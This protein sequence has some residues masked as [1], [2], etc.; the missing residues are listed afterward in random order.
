MLASTQNNAALLAALAGT[1]GSVEQ[2]HSDVALVTPQPLPQDLRPEG[3]QCWANEDEWQWAS[4]ADPVLHIELRKWAR[5]LVVVDVDAQTLAKIALGVCDD[6]LTCVLRAWNPARPV[7]LVPKMAVEAW[8]K[9][10][11]RR[12]LSVIAECMPWIHI[13][14]NSPDCES[15]G[16]QTRTLSPKETDLVEKLVAVIADLTRSEGSPNPSS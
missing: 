7:L 1:L 16:P 11:T 4:R 13:Y 15:R 3:I 6:L 10:Q 9:P 14:S 8:Q 5:L 12:H 2:G